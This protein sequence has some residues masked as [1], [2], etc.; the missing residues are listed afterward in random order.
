[1][2]TNLSTIIRALVIALLIL[3]QWGQ[4]ASP[5]VP[6]L[7]AYVTDLASCLSPSVVSRLNSVLKEF[8]DS[9]STQIV[10]LIIPTLDDASLEEYSLKV[11]ET[12]RVGHKGKDNGVLLLVVRNDRKIRIETGYGAEGALPD[13]LAGQIIR[14]EITPRFKQG[15]YDGG[16]A[17]GALAIMAA[18]KDEYT[19]EPKSAKKGNPLSSLAIIIAIILFIIFSNRNRG[20]GLRSGPS[21]WILGGLGGLGGRSRGG[22]FGG[23]GGGFSGGGFSGGGGSFGGGGSS[24][25]W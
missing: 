20:S 23:G 9:T 6:R 4:A 16:V 22:F 18:L 21:P 2:S 25:S 5:E 1:M 7:S 14:R 24:G 13:A 17:A 11:V 8:D 19:A 10:V 12:N 15:D 3:R